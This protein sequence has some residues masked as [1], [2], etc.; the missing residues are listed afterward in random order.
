MH[1]PFSFRSL[2]QHTASHEAFLFQDPVNFINEYRVYKVLSMRA[3][4]YPLSYAV[5]RCS[6]LVSW[7]D[8]KV[9]FQYNLTITIKKK[10]K[11]LVANKHWTKNKIKIHYA[12]YD[13]KLY[14]RLFFYSKPQISTSIFKSFHSKKIN[15]ILS[16]TLSII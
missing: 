7:C 6:H 2:C 9:T 4:I 10:S 16:S 1:L 14:N 15:S 5:H 8:N 11:N 13:S 3:D 12:K